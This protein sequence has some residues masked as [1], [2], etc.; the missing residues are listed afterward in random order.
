MI[1]FLPVDKPEGPTSHDIVAMAR[2]S[3][4]ARR[5]GHTG[6][7]DPFATGLLILCIGAATRLA[8]YVS[9]L[10]KTYEATARLGVRTDTLD[11]TGE[12]V[13][14]SG[15][16]EDVPVHEVR[17]AFESLV[18]RRSQ[19]PPDYSAKMIAGRRAYEL[20]RAGQAVAPTAVQVDILEARVL[21]VEGPCVRFLLR[22]SSG[23]Y[24]RAIARDAGDALGVGAHLTALRRTAIG[25]FAV[26]DAL[27]VARLEDAGAVAARLVSPLQ[28][29][30]HLPVVELE[31]GEVD[32]VRHGRA[33]PAPAGLASGTVVLAAHGELVAMAE[34]DGKALRPRKVLR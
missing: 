9:G 25:G 17:A 29:V 31:P 21:A 1:G 27:D 23:T 33:I 19:I 6:T 13:S 5:I 32:G 20:A 24:V 7:L 22:C 26:E 16:W 3:L 8:E 28:G 10:D 30:A 18:G 12:V 34:S 15:A 14:T 11:R 2:R 4:G